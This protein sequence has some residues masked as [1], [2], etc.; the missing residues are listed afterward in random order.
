MSAVLQEALL[1]ANK[2]LRIEARARVNVSRFA[3]GDFGDARELRQFARRRRA[4]RLAPP[5]L[6][7]HHD[8]GETAALLR[9]FSI[10][11]SRCGTAACACLNASDSKY[12]AGGVHTVRKPAW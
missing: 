6:G 3:R 9:I 11:A 2:D 8:T 4:A 12:P 10:C 1:V 7:A 5:A